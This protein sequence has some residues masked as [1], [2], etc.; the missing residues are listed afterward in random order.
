MENSVTVS[1]KWVAAEILIVV[2]VTQEE[3]TLTMP[4]EEF[5]TGIVS[6]VA[7]DSRI[8]STRDSVSAR[9]RAAAQGLVQ[10]MKAASVAGVT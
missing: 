7:A 6:K 4:L 2:K 1:R 10:E 8:M 3:I 9:I 5:V